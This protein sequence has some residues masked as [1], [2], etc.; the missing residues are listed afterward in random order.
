MATKLTD[1]KIRGMKAP[2]A[3]QIEFA[4]SDVPGLRVRV[5]VSGAKTFIL[6]R[7]VAGK[8]RN[9]TVGRYGP[10]FGLA[11]AR[12]KARTLV[13]D[14]EA[15]KAPPAPKGRSATAA[16]TIRGM[17]PHYLAAKAELRS[18][19]DTKR[20]LENYVLPELGDRLADTVT[21]GDVTKLVDR[22]AERSLSRARATHAQL[23]AFY[24]W[25]M[26]R[27]DR[28]VANP[29]RD[30]GRPDKPEAR[31]RVLDDDELAALW[32]VAEAEP[33]PWGPAL[34]LLILTGARRNEVFC[35]DRAEF[36]LV[37]AEWTIPPDRAKN[38]VANV[39][40][41]SAPAVVVLKA[42]GG[43]EGGGKLFPSRRNPENG[44][45]GFSKVQGRL[46]VALDKAMKRDTGEHW[47][48]HDIRRTVATGLQKLGVRFE[49]TEAVLNHVSGSRSGIAGVYQRHDWKAEKRAALDSWARFVAQLVEG[50]AKAINVVEL[51][52]RA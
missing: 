42:I 4:D 41:L 52:A 30:A 39:V 23:S 40:P 25:A 27:L 36:D 33:E 45:S 14:L 5:G 2:E 31:D 38:G 51:G 21:R 50:K 10:R 15:G 18:L 17:L 49:V 16:E 28:M 7:R 47:Q 32:R 35:A 43:S 24:T 29:C 22:I 20:I 26:P 48:M 6:R 46:R 34:K 37:G 1:A 12:R 19:A 9:V 3:G 11:D 13:S 44:A 8:V